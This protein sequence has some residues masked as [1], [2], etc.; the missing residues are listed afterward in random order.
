[1]FHN[2]AIQH[3]AVISLGG[4]HLTNDVAVGLRTPTHEAERIKKQYGCAVAA[5]VDKS[6][7]IE[8]PSVGGGQPRVLSRH[9][10][11]EIVEPRVEEIFMLVQHEL[12]KCGMEEI[13]ASGVVITGG[14]T[15]L[16]GMQEM[17]EEVLG[18][19]V[20]RGLPRGIGGL[21][22]VVKSPMYATAVG[23]VI[24]GA[25]QQDSGPYF[26]IREENVYRKVKNR[27]KEWLGQVF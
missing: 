24:Y 6:E 8:V 11:A 14:S 12:Q 19:P 23:L 18:L 22:D 2:G 4:N 25:Q 27:M 20:R 10:L 1:V 26:K 21:V 17:G 7:T 16:A 15:L 3:T 9:I 13:L 5:S